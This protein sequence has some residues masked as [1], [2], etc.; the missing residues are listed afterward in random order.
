MYIGKVSV[1]YIGKASVM[2]IGKVYW[3]IG[4]FSVVISVEICNLK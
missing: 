2:F 3:Y 4:K 1:V